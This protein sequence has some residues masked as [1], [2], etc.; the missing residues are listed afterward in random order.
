MPINLSTNVKTNILKSSQ[1]ETGSRSYL[2]KYAVPIACGTALAISLARVC[3]RNLTSATD[4]SVSPITDP[5]TIRNHELFYQIWNNNP[6]L[7]FWEGREIKEI[8]REYH[9]FP[10]SHQM[11]NVFT[12]EE[13]TR[14]NNAYNIL[15]ATQQF[16]HGAKASGILSCIQTSTNQTTEENCTGYVGIDIPPISNIDKNINDFPGK[17]KTHSDLEKLGFHCSKKEY[18]SFQEVDLGN[19]QKIGLQKF[20]DSRHMPTYNF[21][22]SDAN[23]EE[24]VSTRSTGLTRTGRFDYGHLT[25]LKRKVFRS[26]GAECHDWWYGYTAYFQDGN[27]LRPVYTCDTESNWYKGIYSDWGI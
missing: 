12:E 24:G 9:C 26:L 10:L 17:P 27:P 22:L 16:P 6:Q 20:D 19:G 11:V 4:T 14:F 2:R 18:I 25:D 7:S 23:K 5:T 15:G 1:T 3:L 21:Y 13:T 8:K